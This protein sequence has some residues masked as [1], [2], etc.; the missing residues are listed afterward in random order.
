MRK[1]LIQRQKTAQSIVEYLV[2]LGA[3]TAIVLV[4]FQAFLTRSQEQA[5]VVFNQTVREIM[6]NAIDPWTA[7]PERV[8]YP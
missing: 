3:V 2:L 5:N 7:A 4:G 8:N 6:G 1:F